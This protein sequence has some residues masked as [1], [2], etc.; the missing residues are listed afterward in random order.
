MLAAK[1]GDHRRAVRF[2]TPDSL[3]AYMNRAPHLVTAVSERAALE[4]RFFLGLRLNRGVNVESLRAEFG[5]E[6]LEGCGAA[7][8]EGIH[9]GLLRK[10]GSIISLT[11]QGRLLSNDVFVK[12]LGSKEDE[13][14]KQSALQ[15]GA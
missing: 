1:G 8:E 13:R 12:F 9:E 4:E 6:R 15:P 5:N 2:S 11:A 10:Q 3:D 7:I 14:K